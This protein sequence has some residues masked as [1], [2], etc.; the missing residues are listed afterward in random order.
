MKVVA[1]KYFL[2]QSADLTN[3]PVFTSTEGGDYLIS[4]YSPQVPWG[5]SPAANGGV[6]TLIG[7]IVASQTQTYHFG[8]GESIQV[9]TNFI[10]GGAPV[11]DLYVIVVD[12]AAPGL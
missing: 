11:F 4:V 5:S 8:A 1:K 10:S 7:S 3:A 9:N 2:N 6:T 12:L